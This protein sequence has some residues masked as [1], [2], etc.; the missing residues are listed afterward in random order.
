VDCGCQY[1]C[2]KDEVSGYILLIRTSLSPISGTL[3]CSLNL[4]ASK[5]LLPS[6]VHALVVV[7]AIL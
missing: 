3:A 2:R 4:R 1:Y 7:G 5:P 6:T